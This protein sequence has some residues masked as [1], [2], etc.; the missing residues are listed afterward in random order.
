M[1]EISHVRP[2][3]QRLVWGGEVFTLQHV[4]DPPSSM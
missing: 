1:L 4:V 3:G 2:V